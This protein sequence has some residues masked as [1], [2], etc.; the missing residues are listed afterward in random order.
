[1]IGL[2][3]EELAKSSDVIV[4]GMVESVQS[5]WSADGR[6]IITRASVLVD[7]VIGGKVTG[8]RVMVE[9]PGGE[10]DGIGLKVSD[11]S[12]LMEGEDVLLFLSPETERMGVFVRK[13]VGNAQGEYRI[14]RKGIARKRGFTLADRKDVI[15]NDIPVEELIGKIR[16]VLKD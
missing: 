11:V 3:T 1:M 2:S 13:M 5:E 10:V 6:T 12:P 7:D 16:A 15:D 9:Y 8:N 4:R 14:D